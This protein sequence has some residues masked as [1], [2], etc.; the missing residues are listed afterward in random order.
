MTEHD[1]ICVRPAG[2]PWYVDSKL[3]DGNLFARFIDP[4]TAA[5]GNDVPRYKHPEGVTLIR[6]S[7]HEIISGQLWV[8][9]APYLAYKGD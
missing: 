5:F 6:R 1:L 9:R 4:M 8:N 3:G 2:S 7:G